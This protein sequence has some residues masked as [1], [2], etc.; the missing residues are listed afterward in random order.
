M[1]INGL[2]RRSA[3]VAFGVP[4]FEEAYETSLCL[5]SGVVGLLGVFEPPRNV[6]L[7]L[8]SL[9]G[10]YDCLIT[11]LRLG[12]PPDDKGVTAGDCWSRSGGVDCLE[13]SNDGTSRV[14]AEVLNPSSP[15]MLVALV[16][17]AS[18]LSA[19]RER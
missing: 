18:G 3:A 16:I 5:I 11:L 17:R 2:G 19:S 4:N 10:M 9:S 13:D 15:E 14:R 8:A 1:R 7:T 6:G 12:T